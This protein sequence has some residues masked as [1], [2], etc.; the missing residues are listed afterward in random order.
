MV[1]LVIWSVE[2]HIYRLGAYIKAIKLSSYVVL[3]LNHGYYSS[4]L[5]NR[6][7]QAAFET[8]I[9]HSIYAYI[10]RIK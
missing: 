6:F 7:V 1:V 9:V 8:I 3:N 2:G 10:V 5:N 4:H